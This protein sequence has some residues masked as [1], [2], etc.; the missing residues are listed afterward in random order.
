MAGSIKNFG[1]SVFR[2][3]SFCC[4]PITF[5]S[6]D[7]RYSRLSLHA[8]A[9]FYRWKDKPFIV[10][11]WHAVSGR[12]PL[13]GELL[14]PE[15]A[16]I[17]QNIGFSGLEII[18]DGEQIEIRRPGWM[19]RWDDAFTEFLREPPTI[20]GYPVDIWAMPVPEGVLL[21]PDS[22]RQIF[23][24]SEGLSSFIND[25]ASEELGTA[26]G[27]ECFVIGYPL[28][29]FEGANFP[30]WKM[31]SLASEPLIGLGPYQAFLLDIAS[32][33]G[34]SG[35][36]VVRFARAPHE[37]NRGM[38]TQR[39][40]LRLVGVYGGRLQQRDLEQTNLGYTWFSS[41]ID[42]IIERANFNQFSRIDRVS[43]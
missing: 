16:F 33:T 36:P 6:N 24:G 5:Y 32:T 37:Y 9:F 27:D 25:L 15:T 29:N 26:A 23:F 17:P 7:G 35:S 34:M 28:A 39:L 42:Q 30:V 10:T 14:S 41:N 12:N 13:T 1:Q 11:N 20:D 19:F 31:G 40:S 2:N 8:S 21:G 22:N 18:K 3:I 4:T 43:G 38:V